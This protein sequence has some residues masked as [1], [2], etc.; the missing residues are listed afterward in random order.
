M[1]EQQWTAAHYRTQAN[2][3]KGR[4]EYALAEMLTQAADTYERETAKNGDIARLTTAL[5]RWENLE[6]SICPEDVGFEEFIAGLHQ[7]VMALRTNVATMRANQ[8]EKY[9]RT[10]ELYESGMVDAFD[11]VLT[12]MDGLFGPEPPR[13]QA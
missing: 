1:S 4:R 12:E 3:H 9:H 2:Y 13:E 5:L 6:A 11:Q 8:E 7:K 10:R